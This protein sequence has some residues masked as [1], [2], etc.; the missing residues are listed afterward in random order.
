MHIICPE[1]KPKTD[2]WLRARLN[3]VNGVL[4]HKVNEHYCIDFIL[5]E[6]QYG[7]TFR[8]M[9]ET[10]GDALIWLRRREDYAKLPLDNRCELKY[11]ESKYKKTV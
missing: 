10:Y 6:E 9:F 4:L 3:N 1:R 7:Y 11:Y 5:K 8:V 2:S